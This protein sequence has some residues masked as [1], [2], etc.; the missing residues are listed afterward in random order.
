MIALIQSLDDRGFEQETDG[1][2]DDDG[3]GNR[4]PE[5][6]CCLGQPVSEIR[7]DHVK[8]AVGEIDHAHD[9]EDQGQAA[10]EE[11]E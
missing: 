10:G 2:S 3:D 11:K 4:Q 8:A 1:E 9:A 6:A 5:V 7:A